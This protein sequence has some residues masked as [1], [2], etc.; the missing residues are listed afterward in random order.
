MATAPPRKS[1]AGELTPA[2]SGILTNL[3]HFFTLTSVL[4]PIVCVCVC[5]HDCALMFAYACVCIWDVCTYGGPEVDNLTE[6]VGFF[7]TIY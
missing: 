2:D 7:V 1:I 4:H 6:V 3:L 5:V